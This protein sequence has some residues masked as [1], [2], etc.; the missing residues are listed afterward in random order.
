MIEKEYIE[1]CR[2]AEEIQEQWEPKEG[3]ITIDKNGLETICPNFR[4]FDKG[5]W[6]K[7][8]KWIMRQEDL[9]NIY[10]SNERTEDF[11]SEW[12]S[13][14]AREFGYN[15]MSSNDLTILWLVFVMRELY[16]KIWDDDIKKW[17]PDPISD[18][19]GI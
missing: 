18:R 12:L 15:E 17:I 5:Y 8:T 16:G 4:D 13:N 1:M 9:Q 11:Y 10:F 6:K 3:D 14:Y 2:S 19:Y 7:H